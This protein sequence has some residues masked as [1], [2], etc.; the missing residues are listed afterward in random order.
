MNITAGKI[1]HVDDDESVC[2]STSRLLR[3]SGYGIIS[4]TNG[5]D[6]LELV[7]GGLY[8]DVLMVDF[9]LGQTNGAEVAEQLRCTLGYALPIIILTGDVT[10]AR[11]PHVVE[12]FV[13]LTSKPLDPRLLLAA[14]PN[15]VQLSRATRI[16]C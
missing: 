10:N 5:T 15:L 7:R 3:E 13:W 14:L 11:F 2:T 4:A 8:P 1:L 16:L 9:H 12:A 6:A